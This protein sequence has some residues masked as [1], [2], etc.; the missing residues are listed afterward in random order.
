MTTSGTATYNPVRN[1]VIYGALRKVGGYASGDTPRAEQV[2]DT[3]EELE[4]M[5]KE[6]Q[7]EGFLWLK[8][9]VYVTLV[10]NQ[11]SYQIGPTSTDLVHSDSDA[12]TDY[13]QRPTRIYTPT[14]LNT[15]GYEVP[16]QLLSRADYS[17]LTSKTN[18]GT[19]TQVYY[20]AQMGNGVMYVWLTPPAGVTDK[21]IFTA[22]RII[23]DVGSDEKTLDIPPE[24][25]NA[26]R[27]GLA[28]RIAPE[29]GLNLS[30]RSRL[31]DEATALRDK[32]NIPQTENA[33]TFFQPGR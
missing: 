29:Y 7:A 11:R 13:L 32:A 2:A 9:F 12:T 31:A 4:L 10:A 14:R 28:A 6:W 1:V 27:W 30:E 16:I 19:V 17:M 15:A 18:A 26:V 20:D 3:A 21:I 23:E 24:W 25:L 5:L 22:D 33:S 8:Q